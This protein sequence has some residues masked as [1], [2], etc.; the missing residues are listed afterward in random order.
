MKVF[1][2]GDLWPLNHL[3]FTRLIEKSC[4]TAHRLPATRDR[5]RSLAVQHYG[6]LVC[7]PWGGHPYPTQCKWR[8]I[9]PICILFPKEG[10]L[11]IEN[12][13]HILIY[14]YYVRPFILNKYIHVI[15]WYN[16]TRQRNKLV[17]YIYNSYAL[18]LI[19]DFFCFYQ[20]NGNGL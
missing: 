3:D 9:R 16:I 17:A 8:W 7:F 18:P 4:K 10:W 19:T 12:V 6:R 11:T 15:V 20:I 14:Y 1:R 13:I 2:I 5:A